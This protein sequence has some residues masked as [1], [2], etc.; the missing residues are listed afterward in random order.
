MSFLAAMKTEWAAMSLPVQ[1][2]VAVL[3]LQALFSIMVSVDRLILLTASQIRSR[4]FA[5]K[6]GPLLKN[7]DKN[8]VLALIKESRGSHLAEY[9]EVGIKTFLDRR[10]GGLDDQRAAEFATRALE[11]K[12]EI[13]SSSLNKGMNVLAS[14]GSTAPFIGLLGTVL[15]ILKAFTL[16]GSQG[17]AGM[18]TIG[19][20]IAE[21]LRVTGAG[22]AIAIPTVLLFNFIS[23]K[24]ASYETGLANAGRELVDQLDAGAIVLTDKPKSETSQASVSDASGLANASLEVA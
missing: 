22:L 8:G 19:P 23:A 10:A 6:V 16:I 4:K 9:L 14:T 24:I 11:R 3:F 17:S 12:A 18:T 15:G 1:I 21:A 13:M 20:A 7:G 2:V 5:S